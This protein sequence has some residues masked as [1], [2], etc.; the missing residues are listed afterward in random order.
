[1]RITVPEPASLSDQDLDDLVRAA[2]AGGGW[3]FERIWLALSPAVAG[4]ARS[5][6]VRDVD[7][8]VSNVFLAAFQRVGEFRG[9]GAAF[10]SWLFT[11]AH[12]KIVDDLRIQQR[13]SGEEELVGDDL[14]PAVPS[15]ETAALAAMADD[16]VRELLAGLT[17]DQRDVLLLR[18]FGDLQLAQIA[19][20]LG[21]S[22]GAVKQL[23]HR[24]V[25]Q[26]RK[27]LPP[28][29]A[30]PMDGPGPVTNRPVRAITEMP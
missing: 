25:E 6:G 2:V 29:G 19:E 30:V 11:I 16:H 17:P 12:H 5:R 24:A 21:R 10:R 14:T 18:V 26:L 1:M 7:D 4:Y 20:L 8:V 9:S 13:R 22:E 28:P 15:A 27:R 23:Q 3:A